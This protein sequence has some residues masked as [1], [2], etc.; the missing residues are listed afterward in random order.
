M[1]ST[2]NVWIELQEPDENYTGKEICDRANKMLCRLGV[3]S[4]NFRYFEKDRQY[5]Y[6]GTGMGG[7]TTL[8]DNGKWFNLEYF[9]RDLVEIEG[10]IS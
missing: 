3:E 2:M 5:K 1:K 4:G 8:T 10:T 6:V 7:I 9:G